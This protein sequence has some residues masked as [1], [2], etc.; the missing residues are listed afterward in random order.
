M[1]LEDF[2]E[3]CEQL[4][5]FGGKLLIKQGFEKLS[6]LLKNLEHL[7]DSPIIIPANQHILPLIKPLII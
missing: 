1:Q 5:L 7:R 4:C 3:T 6:I 2:D